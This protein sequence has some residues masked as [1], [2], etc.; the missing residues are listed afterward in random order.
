MKFKNIVTGLVIVFFLGMFS[1]CEQDQKTL[2]TD[3]IWDF[4]N[5]T[6]DSEDENTQNLVFLAKALMTES[7]IE[8]KG[9]GTY[10]NTSPLMDEP[11]SGSWSLIGEDQLILT[12]EDELAST[13]NIE[14]LSKTELKYIETFFDLNQNTYTI[15]TS[16]SRK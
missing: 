6:T 2:L 12:P 1:G 8:F 14:V 7:T 16:W 15:K 5:L 3:G 10:L 13:A 11:V 4:E 9:D